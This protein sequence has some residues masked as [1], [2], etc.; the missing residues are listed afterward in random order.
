MNPRATPATEH[1][2]SSALAACGGLPTHAAL[3]RSSSISGPE[4]REVLV[5]TSR[6][7]HFWDCS[8]PAPWFCD[9]LTISQTHPE[10]G[11]PEVSDGV[12]WRSDH[13]GQVRWR[14]VARHQHEGSHSTV[15]SI[16]CDGNTITL[17]GNVSRFGR[18]DN[19]WGLSIAD[20]INKAN[21]ILAGF[22]LPPFTAGHRYMRTAKNGSA[23]MAWTGARISCLDITANYAAGSPENLHGAITF[24][25]SQHKAKMRGAHGVDGETCYWGTGKSRQQWK[26]YDKANEMRA[27]AKKRKLPLDQKLID[28]VESIGLLRLEGRIRSDA[29]TD[30]GCAFLGD[31][32]MGWA[33][34]QLIKLFDSHSEILGRAKRDLDDLDKLPRVLRGVARDYLAGMDMRSS[35]SKSAFYRHRAALLPFGIDI[36]VNNVVAFKPRVQL[37]ELK[38]APAPSWY[39]LNQL[40]A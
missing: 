8:T 21:A 1:R 28:Y 17:S 32:E 4:G 11:L 23:V 31:Y 22:G 20:C 15:L 39:Q 36:A 9:W 10:G 7:S 13:D 25:Q 12:V 24:L 37:I 16:R 18:A 26:A 2:L 34:P 35:L 40:V 38:A 5:T 6:L 19:V 3:G 29:L 33:M 14:S 30:L 27:H